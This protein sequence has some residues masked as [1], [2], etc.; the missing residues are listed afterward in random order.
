MSVID[1][2][3]RHEHLVEELLADVSAYNPKVDRDL[4]RRAFEFAAKAHD[5]QQR[6][7]GEEFINHP[8]GVAKI[9]AEL[10]L[11]EQTIS[12]ALLHDVV[13]DTGVSIAELREE[14]GEEIARL[15]E[16][17]TKLTRIQF[18][19]RE[20]AQ[21]ENYRKMVVAMASDMRVILIKLADR[22]H[23]M[24]TIEYLGKQKQVQKARETLEVYA[25]LAHRLG[26]QTLKWEL[27][28]LAFEV[29]HPRKYSEIKAMVN[30]QRSDRE[31]HVREASALLKAELDKLDIPSDISGRAKHFYSIYDKM[32]RKG[33]EFNEIYDLTA[34]RVIVENKGEEG[35]RD[36]YGAL[37]LIH[38]LWK[39]MPGRFKDYVA[40]AKA[41]R[42]RSLHTTVIG[43][44]GRPLEIQVRTRE[45]H[46]EAELGIAAHWLYKRQRSAK[47]QEEEWLSWVKQLVDSHASPAGT[48]TGEFMRT[49]RSDLFV[50][51]VYV[52][53]PKGEV[54]TL[55]AGSTPIDF[56]YAVHTDIG[57]RT[58]G[59]KVNGRIVP[60]HYRLANGDFVEIL[61]SRSPRGPSRD[62]LSLAVSS[63]ARNKIRHWLSSQ[64]R[65]E[66]EQKGR[67]SLEQALKAQNLP[68]RKLAGS[69]MLA[70]VIREMGFKKADDFYLALGSGKVPASQVVNKVIQRLKIDEAVPEQTLPERKTRTRRATASDNLGIRVQGVEDP[71]VLLRLAKCC[72][73]VP[74]DKIVGYISMGKGITIHRDD[75]PNVKALRRNPERF[76]RVD[77]DGGTTQCFRVQIAVSAWDRQRLL[78]DVA[79]TFAEHG[80]NIVSYGGAVEDQLAKN[81]YTAELGDVKALKTLLN[82]LHNVDAVFD[83]YRVTPS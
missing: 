49:F 59:A 64:T 3:Q 51:E 2:L 80:A 9:C 1:A 31:A 69:S 82:A 66:T 58:V 54:K 21:A 68:Y 38:S 14:F 20:Q 53:T 5:G 72:N 6:R 65:G 48:D 77:W 4:V 43:P 19:S 76:T 78:E 79:R 8:F 63:R 30:E 61:T 34:M 28:D 18:Q 13:E 7:S 55:P 73:P 37:G 22:L 47:L 75:C 67:D 81:W 15:V 29:L 62:W 70:Q 36:C 27:E 57:H 33:K 50:D 40:M 46:E 11:D 12:A 39:P 60:L 17:V 44:E 45:M 24:R 71:S 56:A 41:N 35:T 74:G 23:N 42:Y 10:R 83:V 26:I 16:G 32:A 52:F 25:P